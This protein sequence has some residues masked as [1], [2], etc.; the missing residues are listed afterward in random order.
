MRRSC[1]VIAL[2]ALVLAVS[3]SALAA[4]ALKLPTVRYDGHAYVELERVAASIRSRVEAPAGGVRAYLRSSGHTVMLTR[5]W[6]RVSVDD[7]PLVLDAPVRV[8]GGVW[9]VPDSFVARVMPKLVTVAGVP[10]PVILP[11]AVV[12]SPEPVLE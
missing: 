2:T 8:K 3:S 1:S 7:R 10:A 9:L 6:A 11:A 5:N 4:G 12:A